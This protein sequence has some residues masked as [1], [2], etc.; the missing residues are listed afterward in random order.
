MPVLEDHPPPRSPSPWGIPE[1]PGGELRERNPLRPSAPRRR[2]REALC[3]LLTARNDLVL[4]RT[5]QIN[6]CARCC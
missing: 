1:R 3:I 6:G 2:A 4:G 5:G